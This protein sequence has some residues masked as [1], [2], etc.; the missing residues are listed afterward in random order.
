MGNLGRKKNENSTKQL[1]SLYSQF[2]FPMPEPIQ[3]H[4]LSML[5][6]PKKSGRGKLGLFP[7]SE[8]P[9]GYDADDDCD[10]DCCD[11]GNFSGD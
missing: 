4:L 5:I 2:H 8:C 9:V 7:F 10:G 3:P 11:D 6:L 1:L